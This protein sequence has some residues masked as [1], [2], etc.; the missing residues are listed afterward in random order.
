MAPP[1]LLPKFRRGYARIQGALFITIYDWIHGLCFR[2]K[3]NTIRMLE[4][5]RNLLQ[6]A[7]ETNWTTTHHAH[8]VLLQKERN[9]VSMG[10]MKKIGLEIQ[11]V[12]ITES[13]FKCGQNWEN[14]HKGKDLNPKSI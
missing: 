14:N 9:V 5:D 6:D 8:L 7:V 3:S 12:S 13:Q 4:Y 11:L 2:G 10:K 1:S